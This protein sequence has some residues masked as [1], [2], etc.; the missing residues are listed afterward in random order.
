MRKSRLKGSLRKAGSLGK[1]W[2]TLIGRAGR[3]MTFYKVIWISNLFKLFIGNVSWFERR[4]N[5]GTEDHSNFRLKR[6]VRQR[7]RCEIG[8]LVKY[9]ITQVTSIASSLF[10]RGGVLGRCLGKQLIPSRSDH[11]SH[12]MWS[13][14]LLTVPLFGYS[15]VVLCF[16]NNWVGD[17]RGISENSDIQ[18]VASLVE[19]N[20]Q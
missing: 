17:S 1:Y 4:R 6:S 14:F 10:P 20:I 12:I 15:T 3:L 13:G 16:L 19:I 5:F 8:V 9:F 18:W 2:W 7:T 11:Q